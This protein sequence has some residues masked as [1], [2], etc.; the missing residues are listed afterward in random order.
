VSGPL[1]GDRTV[2]KTHLFKGPDRPSHFRFGQSKVRAVGKSTPVNRK[3]LLDPPRR[4]PEAPEE[5][6]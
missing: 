1:A 6:G 5:H 4:R 2:E 3:G